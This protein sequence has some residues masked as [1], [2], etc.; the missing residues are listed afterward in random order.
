[1]YMY[2]YIYIYIVRER[3]TT[4]QSHDCPEGSAP[5]SGQLAA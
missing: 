2:I 4:L 5:R 1:M 3:G